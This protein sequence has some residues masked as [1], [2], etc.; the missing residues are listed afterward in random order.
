M[1]SELENLS[2]TKVKMSVELDFDDLAE[3]IAAAYKKIGSQVSIPGFRPGR[4]PRQIMDQRIGRGPILEE[5]VNERVPR[6]YEAVLSEKEIFAVGQPEVEITEIT[7]GERVTFTAEVEIRPDFELPQYK[8]VKLVVDALEVSDDDV[9]EQVDTLRKQFGSYNEVDRAVAQGDVILLDMSAQTADGDPIEELAQTAFSYEVGEDGVV[10]GLDEA[11]IGAQAD[12][13][14]T[15]TFT[16]EF[17]EYEGQ[18]ISV[19]VKVTAVRER[20]LPELNDD[21]ALMASEFDSVAE[22]IEDVRSKLGRRRLLERGQIAR[23]KANDYLLEAVDFPVPEGIISAQIEEHFS[24]DEEH[25]DD[26]HR[27]EVEENARKSLRSQFLLDR[28]ADAEELNVAEAELS[29]WL[30]M[31]A[32]QYGMSPDQF[33]NALVEAGQVPTAVA[34][35]RRG[36]AL[37]FVLENAEIE[38]TNGEP[39]NL[40][41]ID[42]VLGGPSQAVSEPV[43]EDLDEAGSQDS[44]DDEQD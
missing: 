27:A 6:V 32:P 30:M 19:T 13:E 37:A 41:E 44:Q 20:E 39:V 29:Q 1:K 16:P 11:V 24:D 3:D 4:V 31:Q 8:G 23:N 5:V 36:K 25:G 40:D 18:D 33:A 38:D 12:E 28:I 42:Q 21:F 15:F 9:N 34:E 43:A 22:L 14:R 17:G 26:D 2:E 10:P 7:D 35:V